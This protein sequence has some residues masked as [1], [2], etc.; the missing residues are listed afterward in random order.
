VTTAYR[1]AT[2]TADADAGPVTIEIGDDGTGDDG[3]G[4]D[5]TGDDGTGDDG[6]GTDRTGRGDQPA[7]DERG[8][9]SDGDADLAEADAVNRL[10]EYVV[11]RQVAFL[12]DSGELPAGTRVYGF[13]YDAGR[14]YGDVR[15]RA[16]LVNCDGETDVDLVA[17]R[18]PSRYREAVRRVLD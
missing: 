16:Y 15:G 14:V 9:A 4:D 8:P 5:G 12:R 7:S 13:V 2:G 18:V 1:V 11:D 3:T 10:V 6:T 17:D